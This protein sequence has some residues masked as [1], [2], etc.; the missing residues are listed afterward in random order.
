[1]LGVMRKRMLGL[2]LLAAF[3]ALMTFVGWR[4]FASPGC[5]INQD[6]FDQIR[7]GMSQADVEAI[8][9]VPPGYHGTR[10]A[11]V[12]PRRELHPAIFTQGGI[13]VTLDAGEVTTKGWVGDDGAI[14]LTFDAAGRVIHK[15]IPEVDYPDPDP[16]GLIE[17]LR[18]WLGW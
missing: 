14:L 8:L 4:T 9:G 1:M 18:S 6:N 12:S 10:R 16:P 13:T 5:R 7:E 11:V 17:R 3:T 15:S 2:V